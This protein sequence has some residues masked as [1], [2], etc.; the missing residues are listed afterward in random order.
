V[1]TS[2]TPKEALI[3]LNSVT[4][5]YDN[6]KALDS[7]SF[8]IDKGQVFGYIGP[9]GA[10]KTTTIKILVGLI[11]NFKGDVQILGYQMPKH[12]YEIHKFLGYLPQNVAFQDWQT[13]DN[14]LKTFGLLSGLEKNRVEN[15]IAEVLDFLS[16]SDFRKKKVSQLSGGMAQKVGLAQALLHNPKLLVLDEPMGGLDPASRKQFK[17]LISSLA[18]EGTTILFS[19]HILSDVQDVATKIGILNKGKIRKIGTVDELKT[20]VLKEKIVEVVLSAAGKIPKWTQIPG[21]K[22]IEQPSPDRI[23]IYLDEEVDDDRAVNAFLEQLLKSGNRLRS[24]NPLMPSLD[25][26]YQS[27]VTEVDNS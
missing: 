18:K 27:Y 13:V 4:K 21:I 16:L 6:F 14:A 7:V 8:E 15:R 22:S 10:G 17:K 24:L 2:D 26:V 3:I 12:K 19:S 23:L 25:E 1:A 9:N 20:S 11:T 5:N